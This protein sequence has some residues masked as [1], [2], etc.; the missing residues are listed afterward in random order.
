MQARDCVVLKKYCDILI[1]TFCFP[2][3]Y[4]GY[5]GTVNGKLLSQIYFLILDNRQHCSRRESASLEY[6]LG[7]TVRVWYISLSAARKERNEI[8]VRLWFG[9]PK[10]SS[11]I[12]FTD[13][14]L[15]SLSLSL[16][17]RRRRILRGSNSIREIESEGGCNSRPAVELVLRFRTFGAIR[18]ASGG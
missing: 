2:K 14:I 10:L 15:L 18:F 16:V 1:S 7:C 8:H 6:D 4:H 12:F 9:T 3:N 17:F 5:R 13:E 11:F